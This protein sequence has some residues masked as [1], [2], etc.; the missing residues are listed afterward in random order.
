VADTAHIDMYGVCNHCHY[1]L[2][3]SWQRNKRKRAVGLDG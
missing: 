1:S 3:Q 2:V